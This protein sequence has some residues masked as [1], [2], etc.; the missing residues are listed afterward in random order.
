M[1][2]MTVCY[3]GVTGSVHEERAVNILT[4]AR[5]FTLINKLKQCLDKQTVK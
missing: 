1:T 2:N 5:L 4:L 3:N